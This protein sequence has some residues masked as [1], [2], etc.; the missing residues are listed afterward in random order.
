MPE[1]TT[2]RDSR[3]ASTGL[4][5]VLTACV[6]YLLLGG[7]KAPPDSAEPGPKDEADG[8]AALLAASAAA[9]PLRPLNDY[10]A[11]TAAQGNPFSDGKVPRHTWQYLIVTVP[12]P[13]DSQFGFGFD[14]TLDATMRALETEGW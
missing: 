3:P 7:L 6:S 8:Q 4:W 14:Q 9:E 11:V 10:F 2:P 5:V 12:D 1:P 13:I